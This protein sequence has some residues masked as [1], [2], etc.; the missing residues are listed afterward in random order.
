MSD[1]PNRYFLTPKNMDSSDDDDM[2][3]QK[4][5]D[6][7]NEN[8]KRK[9]RQEK[10]DKKYA[11][12]VLGRNRQGLNDMRSAAPSMDV[13]TAQTT[14]TDPDG[15]VM[16]GHRAWKKLSVRM[17]AV[18]P[19]GDLRTKG[20]QPGTEEE[21]YAAMVAVKADSKKKGDVT[22]DT[23]GKRPPRKALQSLKTKTK[24]RKS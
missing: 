12:K 14:L 21:V 9:E 10:K 4:M 20:R 6:G 24:Q 5:L 11:S 7:M 15:C 22:E 1:E 3:L 13:L 18:D 8:K 16:A 17:S 2:P 23:D 19:Y